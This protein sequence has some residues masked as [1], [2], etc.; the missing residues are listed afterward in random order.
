MRLINIDT[1]QIKVRLDVDTD[2]L[3]KAA[4]LAAA[5]VLTAASLV[6]RRVK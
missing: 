3:K 4:T 5:V 6:V 1:P 2:G